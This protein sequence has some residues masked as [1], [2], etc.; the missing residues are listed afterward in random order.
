MY[1]VS[2]ADGMFLNSRIPPDFAHPAEEIFARILDF[3]GIEWIY[4]PKT[5]PLMWDEK[6]A[7]IEAFTPDFT[8]LLRLCILS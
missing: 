1:G 5:F 6:G 8:S 3:Y 2:W 4:E 7:V